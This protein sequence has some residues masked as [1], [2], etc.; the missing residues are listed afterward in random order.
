MINWNLLTKDCH[1][2]KETEFLVVSDIGDKDAPAHFDICTWYRKGTKVRCKL[3]EECRPKQLSEKDKFI[4][5]LYGDYDHRELE[6]PEDGFYEIT[7]DYFDCYGDEH[8]I[9]PDF[10][11]FLEIPEISYSYKDNATTY[12]ASLPEVPTGLIHP[13]SKED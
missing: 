5:S 2:K 4:L 13:Y 12:W 10:K 9:Y 7:G 3:K 1:P 8:P 6:I 11:D